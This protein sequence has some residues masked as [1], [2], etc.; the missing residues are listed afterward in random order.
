MSKVISIRIPDELH[1]KIVDGIMDNGCTVSEWLFIR[2][3]AYERLLQKKQYFIRYLDH[4]EEVLEEGS[5]VQ[6][7]EVINF[8]RQFFDDVG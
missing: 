3:T 8:L 1:D 7:D 2:I 4:L 5:N 6:G